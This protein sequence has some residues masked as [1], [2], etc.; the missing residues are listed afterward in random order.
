MEQFQLEGLEPQKGR[1]LPVRNHRLRRGIYLLPGACTVGNLFCGYFAIMATLKGGAT[2]LDY[3]AR[4]IGFAF[5]FDSFDG[6][7]ARITRT[8]SE[9]GREL[10]SLADVVSFGIAPA[11][12]AFAWGAR[13]MLSIATLEAHFTYKF[14]WLVSFIFV[15]CC[16]WRLARF[17]IQGMAPESPRY[18]V[19]LPAPAAAATIAAIVHAFVRSWPPIT[20]WRFSFLWLLVVLGLAVLMPSKTRY[21][22][23]KSLQL[24]KR[25]HSIA[26]LLIAVLIATIVINSEVTLLLISSFYVVQG[27]VLHAI[28]ALRRHG[29]PRAA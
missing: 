6:A 4:A 1:I 28:R 11:F 14:G 20:D 17:N 15:A 19:G 2:D 26:I 13:G 22:T 16:A 18:F 9:L 10:D 29:T 21:W 3:A 23:F 27:I 7:L 8:S 24:Q 12:L 25:Y 5:L